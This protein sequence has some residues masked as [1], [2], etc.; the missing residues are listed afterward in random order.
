[1]T[2]SKSL[3]LTD[4]TVSGLIWQFA[5]T[6]S[7]A[8]SRIVVMI[9]L[10]RL[11]TPAE[12]GVATAAQIVITLSRIVSQ[13]GMAP[14]I[15]QRKSLEDRHIRSAFAFSLYSG[16]A[17]G[18]I[19]MLCAPLLA[20]YFRMP[21]LTRFVAVLA[22]SLPIA[23][24]AIVSEGLLLRNLEFK[25][26]ALAETS[27]FMIGYGVTGVAL[28]LLGFGTWSLI[29]AL[30]AQTTMRSFIVFMQA[31]HDLDWRIR[32]HSIRDLLYFSG[33]QS[34][35]HFGNFIALQA[36]NV[37]VARSMGEVALGLYGRA[38]QLLTLPSTLFG[39]VVDRVLF[40]AMASVQDDRER[41]LKAFHR[42]VGTIAMITLPMSALLILLA[43]ELVPLL[44]GGTWIS[45]VP[46]F[47]I[48]AAFLVFRT[49]YKISD[50]LARARGNVFSRAWRQWVY[51]GA[52]VVG[53]SV[54]AERG[55]VGVA[56]G[57]GFAILLNFFLMMQL[58]LT[59]IG[60]SWLPI[61]WV[62]VRHLLCSVAIVAPAWAVVCK[63]RAHE[64]YPI[65]VVALGTGVAVVI[66]SLLVLLVPFVFGRDGAWLMSIVLRRRYEKGSN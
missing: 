37:V 11:L 56:M 44:L 39:K 46:P 18:G 55:L 13:L 38:Y 15:V 14:A 49:S 65:G 17:A 4:R 10:A 45:I 3:T 40:P 6:G 62:H 2:K 30:L 50:S 42:A 27:S 60:G 59:S 57:V 66:G 28:A 63:A 47:Q 21:Q 20:D 23:N 5:G 52:V 51:A 58:S 31:R 1:M 32:W 25:R 16:I 8:V 41:L 36:D 24:I 9:A 26:L 53:A 29:W 48:L 64:V 43:P 7:E 33:G 22:L 19:M 12:F 54:G 35:S 61:I 34:L